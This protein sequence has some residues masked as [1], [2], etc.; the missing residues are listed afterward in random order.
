MLAA[1]VV[2]SNAMP[3]ISGPEARSFVCNSSAGVPAT[4]AVT[5]DGRQVPVIRWT[6]TAFND[7]G[8]SQE[9]RCQ[10]V[11]ARFD[12]FLKQGRLVYITTG[13]MNGLPVIC[14]AVRHGGPCVGLLYTLKP[15]QDA[16]STLRNLLQL[17]AKARGPLNETTPR[18]YVSLDELLT[19]TTATPA[20]DSYPHVS[21]GFF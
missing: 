14:T 6:S 18:L 13:R 3:A 8:W 16:P 1:S 7:A 4:S 9:R 17:R 15:G 5:A 11:S 2:V 20:G 10:E 19:P 12:G 21:G